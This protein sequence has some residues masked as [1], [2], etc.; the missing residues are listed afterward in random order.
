MLIFYC[1]NRVN[2]AVAEAIISVERGAQFSLV[3]FKRSR[4]LCD[5]MPGTLN[6]PVNLF[7]LLPAFFLS[8]FINP[9]AIYVPHHRLP[10]ILTF[11]YYK[12]T[13]RFLIDDGMDTLRDK[14]RNI[15]VGRL[16]E[17]DA[18]FSFT[19]LRGFPKWMPRSQVRAITSMNRLSVQDKLVS[20]YL[21]SYD[22]FFF[23][24]PGLDVGELIEMMGIPTEKALVFPHPVLAK[25]LRS[26]RPLVHVGFLHHGTIEFLISN[27]HYKKLFFGETMA[28]VYALLYARGRNNEIY[29]QM[30][31]VQWGNLSS[32]S[33]VTSAF[34]RYKNGPIRKAL[35]FEHT[36]QLFGFGEEL[37]N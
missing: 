6:L 33:A 29:L 4:F 18:Y 36:I 35:E 17:V 37:Q 2:L 26:E 15:T 22:Y 9:S 21:L 8:F 10:R 7:T 25:R 23:E 14:P 31:E 27:C 16:S 19:E 20:D 24:S 12:A 30:S 34:I 13:S 3:Y 32:I 5:R 11:I 28:A 1:T